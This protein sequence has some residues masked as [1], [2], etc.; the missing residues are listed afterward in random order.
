MNLS[1]F[2]LKIEFS[3]NFKSCCKT[4]CFWGPSMISAQ[5]PYTLVYQRLIITKRYH[6]C[7]M[8]YDIRTSYWDNFDI[9][10][11]THQAH[12]EYFSKII[13]FDRKKNPRP[14]LSGRYIVPGGCESKKNLGGR[15]IT[16]F[17]R[18]AWFWPTANY[19]RPT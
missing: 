19:F 5:I 3:R 14:N 10:R 7:G 9:L 17:L 15:R 4:A 18:P 6:Y 11:C 8:L 12:F 1:N 16:I 2:D 13:F